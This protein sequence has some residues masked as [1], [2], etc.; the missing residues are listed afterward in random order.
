MPTL[1]RALFLLLVLLGVARAE[2]A[3]G[4][5]KVKS[6]VEG[7]E[8]W[9]DGSLLGKTPLTKY[10]PPG[11]HQVRVIADFHDPFVRKV[12]VASDKTVEIQ[13]QLVKGG[14]TL[15]FVGP[16]GAHV[17]LAGQD[18]GPTPIRLPSP[19]A[20]KLAWRVV[21]PGFEPVE[22]VLDVVAG[23]NHLI[24]AKAQSSRGVLE[25][26]ST[27]PG[28]HVRLDGAVVGDTPLK[29]RDV[30][31]GV[32]GVEV[33]L[34]GKSTSYRSVDTSTGDRAALSV[35]LDTGGVTL[36]VQTGAEDARV[37]LNDA[38]AGTGATVKL[39]AVAKG[40]TKVRVEAGG[41]VASKTVTLPSGGSFALRMAGGQLVEKK[42]LYEQWAFWAAVGGGAATATTVVAIVAT[43][44]LPAPP[45]DG[46]TVVTLP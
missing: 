2:D 37:Y 38:L 34:E 25:I 42:K 14:G 13:A 5:L 20:G 21:A 31:A 10:L 40:R 29:L 18:K 7:A 33:A 30:A 24:E 9:L 45:P 41:K 39:A 1:V 32:H 26:T 8:V 44:N 4:V 11:S 22:G 35:A 12:D 17:Y 23:R 27:P 43:A 15:E 28:A 46:D 16:A 3:T 6:N 36:T 19:G